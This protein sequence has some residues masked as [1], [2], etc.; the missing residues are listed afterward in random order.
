MSVPLP[1]RH[2]HRGSQAIHRLALRTCGIGCSKT[3]LTSPFFR[4][5]MSTW[6]PSSNVRKLP[7]Q[8]PYAMT[9]ELLNA[10]SF[11]TPAWPN[12]MMT[13]GLL[14]C[15]IVQRNQRSGGSE[16]CVVMI[17]RRCSLLGKGWS[18]SQAQGSSER[19]AAPRRIEMHVTLHVITYSKH[20]L[21]V[22]DEP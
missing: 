12:S 2:I 13:V 6:I 16:W 15:S 7:I 19:A 9:K 21:C 8:R 1:G 22:G 18:S 3:H 14:F 17:C 5:S 4:R 10:P 20:E 11:S